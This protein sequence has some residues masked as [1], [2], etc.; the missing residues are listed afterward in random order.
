MPVFINAYCPET[1]SDDKYFITDSAKAAVPL[2]PM[3]NTS[4]AEL[5]DCSRNRN[6]K[7]LE[8]SS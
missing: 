1:L 8:L 6:W 3:I 4:Q 5:E 2:M 7:F